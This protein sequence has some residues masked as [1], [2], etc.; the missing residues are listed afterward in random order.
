M[1]YGI[2]QSAL[3]IKCIFDR[4]RCELIGN[5]EM[6]NLCLDSKIRFVKIVIWSKSKINSFISMAQRSDNGL[7]TRDRSLHTYLIYKLT[8]SFHAGNV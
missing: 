6:K 2:F 1:S 7:T 3:T 8:G 4:G 5:K